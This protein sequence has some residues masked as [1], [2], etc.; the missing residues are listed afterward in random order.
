MKKRT[1]N[2]ILAAVIVTL[3]IGVY[4]S[5]P[6]VASY[7]ELRVID[8]VEHTCTVFTDAEQPGFEGYTA[9]CGRYD[10]I[11]FDNYEPYIFVREDGTNVHI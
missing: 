7:E 4:A 10:G 2:K 6:E 9:V 5:A 3:S 8:G 11:F 1:E